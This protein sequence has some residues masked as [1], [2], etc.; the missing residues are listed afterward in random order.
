MTKIAD[1]TNSYIKYEDGTNDRITTFERAQS[2]AAR[3]NSERPGTVWLPVDRGSHVSPQFTVIQFTI[4]V[5]DEVSMGFNG[6]YYP[7]GKVARVSK[8]YKIVTLENGKR[9]FRRKQTESWKFDG[10]W[11]LVRGVFDE[12][13]PSF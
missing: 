4:K 9:F 5:G 13:N 2:V 12:R 8:D 1:V 7:Q 10:T 6:D 11:G 3:L